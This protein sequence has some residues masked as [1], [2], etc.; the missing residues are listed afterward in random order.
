MISFR[1]KGEELL[2]AKDIGKFVVRTVEGGGQRRKGGRLIQIREHTE[3][4]EA[5]IMMDAPGVCAQSWT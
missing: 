1:I 3:L 2:R 5:K 4:C